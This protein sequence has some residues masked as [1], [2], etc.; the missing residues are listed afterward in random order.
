VRKLLFLVL[1]L[2]FNTITATAG[3]KNKKSDNIEEIK[4]KYTVSPFFLYENPKLSIRNLINDRSNIIY[5]P[6]VNGSFGVKLGYKKFSIAL[7][8]KLPQTNV[9][10][11]T[12]TS[13]IGVDIQGKNIGFAVFYN[14]YKGLYLDNYNHFS[15]HELILRPDIKYYATGFYSTI[16]FSKDFS[17]KAAF[18]QTERQKHTAGSFMLMV[19]DKFTR[20]RADSSF[21]LP[22]EQEWYGDTKD[23][24]ATNT[25][26][27]RFTPG[28]GM[29]FIFEEY[30]SVTAVLFTGFDFQLNFYKKSGKTKLRANF[31][32]YSQG[33]LAVGYNKD[34]WFCNL[35]YTIDMNYIKFTD[36]RFNIYNNYFKISVGKR[37]GSY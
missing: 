13:K 27:I 36:S 26:N 6:N 37:F 33:R 16:D 2:V 19:G 1:I 23:I 12:K 15:G 8:F 32:F 18:A 4:S 28:Y 11:N 7:A 30:F 34:E 31:P 14:S 35:I 29:S 5:K 3:S 21:I 20:V 9:Y 17:M 10:G 24:T 25:N 22:E